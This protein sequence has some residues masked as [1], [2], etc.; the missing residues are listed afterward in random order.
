MISF[1]SALVLL[2]SILYSISKSRYY[3]ILL[4]ALFYYTL[5]VNEAS[6]EAAYG[7][8]VLYAG[9][10]FL[11]ACNVLFCLFLYLLGGWLLPRSGS[12]RKLVFDEQDW[13]RLFFLVTGIF[14]IIA[15]IKARNGLDFLMLN[16]SEQRSEGLTLL[17]GV[18]NLL[19]LVAFSLAPVFYKSR[20]K[21]IFLVLC[22]LG[23][24]M[25]TGSRAMLFCLGGYFYYELFL[26]DRISFSRRLY[27]LVGGAVAALSM[28][29]LSRA[30]RG[31]GL[32]AMLSM[33]FSSLLDAISSSVDGGGLFG[34]EDNIMKYYFYIVHKYLEGWSAGP[35]PTLHRALLILLPRELA[36][37]SLKPLDVTYQVWTAALSDG[38]F[39]DNP[40]LKE[41]IDSSH[42]G[43]P[44]SLHF[45]I[46]GDALLNAGW[47]G[48]LLYP[49]LFAFL[50]TVFE[51]VLQRAPPAMTAILLGLG[52][53]ALLMIAR[54]NIV[55]GLGYII[56]PLPLI[57]LICR[58]MEWTGRTAPHWQKTDNNK[59]ET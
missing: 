39:N 50:L 41:M 10:L 57:Y 12:Y 11:F 35:M 53:P 29:V 54:G 58:L 26:S 27:V 48:V 4:M 17:D 5:S 38:L 18:S 42:Q 34:G 43:I 47:F 52:L 22:C 59:N 6:I 21:F 55:I 28:H 20:I 44:G 9:M 51:S 1:L 23:V 7:T 15:L 3:S 13:K 25:V 32:S 33:D 31:I 19:G 37:I 49:L 8:R 40:W 56:Y 2:P 45:L 24:F 36:D 30:A 46:W 16:W 14:V